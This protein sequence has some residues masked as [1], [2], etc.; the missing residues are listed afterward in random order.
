[1]SHKSQTNKKE[2]PRPKPF[3]SKPIPFDMAKLEKEF[4]R[5]DLHFHGVDHS[6]VSYEGRIFLNNPNANHDTTKTP[7]NGYAGSFHVFGH[8]GCYGDPGH[9]V[10]KKEKREYDNRSAHPLTPAFMRVVITEGLKIV[11]KNTKEITVTVVPVINGGND[12]CD[13]ENVLVFEKI[14]LVTYD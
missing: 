12:M 9:C 10:V 5:A 8:G 2:F 6:G 7:N 13:Y 11:A 14:S 1:M 3:V 4:S